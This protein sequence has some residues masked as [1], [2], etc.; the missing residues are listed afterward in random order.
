MSYLS[1]GCNQTKL[2]HD[3]DTKCLMRLTGCKQ[4]QRAINIHELN[5]PRWLL[6]V[7]VSIRSKKSHYFY[8]DSLQSV[9]CHAVS[10]FDYFS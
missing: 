3:H 6:C 5:K 7:Y 8:L 1:F 4:S 10:P 9:S 2:G